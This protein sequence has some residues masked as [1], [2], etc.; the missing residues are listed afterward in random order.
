MQKNIYKYAIHFYGG[1]NMKIAVIDAQG[2]GFGQAV[3]KKIRKEIHGNIDIIALG[4]NVEAT[5]N[6]VRVRC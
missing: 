1:I 3:I 6:M 2:A 4:T 5:S